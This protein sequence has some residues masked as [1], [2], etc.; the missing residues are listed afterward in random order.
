MSLRLVIPWRVALQQTS[1]PL[2][3]PTEILKQKC[4]FEK[5]IF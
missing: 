2:H 4:Q 3:Q 1:P 5:E